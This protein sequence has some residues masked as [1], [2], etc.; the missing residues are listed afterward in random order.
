MGSETVT[1]VSQQFLK[2]FWNVVLLMI[3]AKVTDDIL[4]SGNYDDIK[5]FFANISS[6]IYVS[7][8]IFN[9]PMDSS[10]FL[11]TQGTHE[12]IILDLVTYIRSIPAFYITK[13]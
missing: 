4:F 6:L 5:Y 11:I 8:E 7:K 2:I 10:G 13:N 9:A 3:L 1:Y 12:Y